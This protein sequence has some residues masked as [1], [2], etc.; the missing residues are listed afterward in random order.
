MAKERIVVKIGS[1]SLTNEKGEL[2]L[3]KLR[4]HVHALAKLRQENHE[5]I[6]VSSGAVAAGF[7]GL[8]YSSRPVTVKGKQAA[9]AVGQSILIQTYMEEF[10]QFQVTAAQILL[11]RSDF[12]NRV[13]YQNAFAT[14]T[15]L[16]DRGVLPIINENDTVAVDE[17]TFGDN[18]MLSALVSGFVHADRLIILTDINGIYTDNPKTNPEAM[19]YDKLDEITKEMIKQAGAAGSKVGTG[20]MKSKLLAAKTAQ[21][22]GVSVFIGN[23]KGKD[24]L[25]NVLAGKG[26]GTYINELDTTLNTR[27]QWIALHSES[28]GR[29]YVDEG[30]QDAILYHGKSLLSAGVF[31]VKGTFE[32][33]DVVE[34]IG[35]EGF[36]GK[37]EV[38]CSS[39]ELKGWMDQQKGT[40]AIEVIHRDQ[41]VE[42]K[43]EE[44]RIG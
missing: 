39:E 8:G 13:R 1:S 34:V 27:K 3:E 21:S 10:R 12:S 7:R 18:D 22:L 29:I 6:L 37:G 28:F 31:K 23:G 42:M 30:A 35:T 5:V 43:Y 14:I 4:D 9:A 19:K 33:G 20:G 40:R 17:L 11:T 38:K 15:E 32:K 41:W 16:L 26:N 24:K 36:L 2:D 44:E 25:L